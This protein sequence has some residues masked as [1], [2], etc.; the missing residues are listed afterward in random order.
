M[1]H[2]FFGNDT[3]AVRAKAHECA[4]PFEKEGVKLSRID[5]DSYE[6]GAIADV[7]GAVSLFGEKALYLIDMPSLDEVFS[8]EVEG[9]LSALH[10]SENTFI[11][12][13]GKLLAPAKKVLQKHADTFEEIAAEKQEAFNVF[14]LADSLSRRDKKMLWLGLCEAKAAGSSSEELIGTLWWQLKTLRLAANTSSAAQAG[15]KDFPYNKA[16]RSLSYFKEGDLERI[17]RSLLAVYH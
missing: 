3:S 1:L 2:V 11:I 17:S 6:P 12:I 7:V 5:A 15:M 10:E 4:L 16:K 9:L 13:E 8:A 14:A